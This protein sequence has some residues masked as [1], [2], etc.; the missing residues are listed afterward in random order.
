MI[1]KVIH[2]CWFGGNPLP[3]S[4]VQ[5][6]K[7]WEKYAPDYKIL[8]WNES[9]FDFH[10]CS[11]IEE[12]YRVK[13]WAFVS[14]YARFYILYHEGGVY[15][16]TDVELIAPIENILSRGPFMGCEQDARKN[17]S[18]R[19]APGLGLASV[20]GM[21]FYKEILNFYDKQ[22]FIRPDGSL[23]EH[24]VVDYT[25]DLLFKF[26]LKNKSGIQQ[27]EDITIYPAEYFCPLDYQTG[28]LTITPN[29]RSIHHYTA[30]WHSPLEAQCAKLE[31]FFCKKYGLQKGEKYYHVVSFPYRIANR[32]QQSGLKKTI[33]YAFKKLKHKELKII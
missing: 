20:S 3:E 24:T 4:A 8:E 27:I 6:I 33:L 22:H 30:T 32:M 14:D 9:N 25:T 31:R 13:K 26:G 29:T 15:F 21:N 12:A 18:I 28:K 17:L 19:I 5:C 10:K 2:Y 16:D 11:Y 23:N 7:S 1:P